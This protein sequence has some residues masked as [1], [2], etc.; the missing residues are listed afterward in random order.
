MGDKFSKLKTK[1]LGKKVFHLLFAGY[2]GSGKTSILNQLKYLEIKK[3]EPTIG[4][5][6]ESIDYRGLS[7]V[8]WDAGGQDKIRV[9]WK[10]YY[11][12][13]DGLIYVINCNER[14]YIEDN[15]EEIRKMLCEEVLEGC[16]LLVWANKQDEKNAF[17]PDELK[18]KIG[19]IKEENL[20]SLEHLQL[21]EKVLKKDLIG[22]WI[23]Y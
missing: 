16:P 15:I 18:D 12:N 3:T 22:W 5:N 14:D 2:E 19:E 6:I 23:L 11:Q 10:H 9:L 4:Y 1:F 20:M 21:L 7:F 8:I 17:P 13:I